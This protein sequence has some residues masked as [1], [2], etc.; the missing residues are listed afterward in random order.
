MIYFNGEKVEFKKF[1]NGESMI[2]SEN[3]KLKISNN[4]IKVKFE[5][6]E[7]I[8]HL[9]FLKG[10]L[11][12]L[13]VKSNLVFPYMPYSRMDRTEGIM[14]FTLKHLC[15]LIN[16]LNFESVTIYE[17]HSDV[18]TALLDRVKVVNMSKILAEDLLKKLNNAKEDVYLVYPDAGAAKRYGKDISY[19]K[20]LTANKERDF[21]TGFIKKLDINGSV[22][23]KNFKA[24]I[25]DDLCSKGGTFVL[26]ASKLKEMGADEIYLV[27]THLEDTVFK[28]ELLENDLVKAIYATD[29]ILSKHHEKIKVYEI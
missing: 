18:C 4:E 9:I 3:L 16:S 2:H 22:K 13:K 5:N 14:I 23:D 17:P 11:D 12:E 29:S 27:V 26:T 15:R 6:D 21:K 20:I 25:V 10:H 28:G 7:D 8:T 19:E 24:I 1:P